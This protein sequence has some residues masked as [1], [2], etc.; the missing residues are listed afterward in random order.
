M[1]LLGVFYM[2][3]LFYQGLAASILKEKVI[4]SEVLS[5]AGLSIVSY[6]HSLTNQ[7]G[8]SKEEAQNMAIKALESIRY[9][10]NGYY[11]INN[12]TGVVLMHPYVIDIV[13]RNQ[14]DYQ[15]VNGDYPFRK[16]IDTAVKGGGGQVEYF[17][18]KPS[19]L[20]PFQKV[21]HV[22]Y[23]EPWDWVVGTGLYFDD[24]QRDIRKYAL[25]AMYVGFGFTVLL[26]ISTSL[27]T[28][29]VILQLEDIAI[30]DPLTT[31]N[32][33]RF[34]AENMQSLVASH[35][36]DKDSYLSVIFF[37]IDHF[38]IIN[39]I[40][41][42]ATGDKVISTVGKILKKHSRPSDLSIRYG[43]E[44][45]VIVVLDKEEGTALHLAERISSAVK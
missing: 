5:D 39:D 27:V 42:H 21:S 2:F 38:K 44:E 6:F 17:W 15:D 36:R 23:F 11:W 16:I 14:M 29:R 32:T 22:V 7:Q 20:E 1:V 4:Q 9:G 30:R 19:L 3:F 28:K 12:R 41:G 24:I 33:R 37:D 10:E 8:L 18:P 45:F 31:L 25:T 35:E 26:V 43:G 13:N 40:Y 34:L